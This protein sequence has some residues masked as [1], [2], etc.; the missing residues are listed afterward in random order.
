[1]DAGVGGFPRTCLHGILDL[2]DVAVASLRESSLDDFDEFPPHLAFLALQ[3]DA[4]VAWQILY[5]LMSAFSTTGVPISRYLRG[6]HDLIARHLTTGLVSA[7]LASPSA[8]AGNSAANAL[9]SI[10]LNQCSWLLKMA[11][12]EIQFSTSQRTYLARLLTNL[13]ATGDAAATAA[14]TDESGVGFSHGASVDRF[15]LLHPQPD[16][17][18]QGRIL[19]DLLSHMDPS[20]AMISPLWVF[21]HDCAESRLVEDI[22]VACEEPFPLIPNV[23]QAALRS[24]VINTLALARRLNVFLDGASGDVTDALVSDVAEWAQ[25]RNAHRLALVSGKQAY[26]EGWR[27]LA[28]ISMRMLHFLARVNPDVLS[29]TSTTSAATVSVNRYLFS[30]AMSLLGPMLR[31]VC[32][33]ETSPAVLKVLASGSCLSLAAFLQIFASPSSADGAIANPKCRGAQGVLSITQLLL[34]AVL[35]SSEFLLLLIPWSRLG[36]FSID[37]FVHVEDA[38]TSEPT[39]QRARANYYG[40]LCYVLDVCQQLDQQMAASSDSTVGPPMALRAINILSGSSDCD[41]GSGVRSSLLTILFNDLSR[42]HHPIIPISALGLLCMLMK[43]DRASGQI[44]ETVIRDG[45]LQS[46]VDSLEDDLAILQ[47]FLLTQSDSSSSTGMTNNGTGNAKGLIDATAV[48]YV[49]QSKMAFLTLAASTQ[50]GA[51]SLIQTHLLDSTLCRFEPLSGSCLA[52]AFNFSVAA[53]RGGG[54]GGDIANENQSDPLAWLDSHEFAQFLLAMVNKEEAGQFFGCASGLIEPLVTSQLLSVSGSSPTT[55]ADPGQCLTWIGILEPALAFAKALAFT[56][57]PSHVSAVQKVS[58]F[59]YTHSDA[60]LTVGASTSAARLAL[61]LTQECFQEDGGEATDARSSG[62]QEQLVLAILQWLHGE[63]SLAHLLSFILRA[64]IPSSL[65]EPDDLPRELLR[66]KTLRHV[67][68]ILHDL[69]Q[70]LQVKEQ[71]SLAATGSISAKQT[72]MRNLITTKQ[73][74]LLRVLVTT[75]V[76]AVSTEDEF[77][78]FESTFLKNL[79]FSSSLSPRVPRP[80]VKLFRLCLRSTRSIHYPLADSTGEVSVSDGPSGRPS[81]HL[82]L[83]LVSWSASRL[84]HLETAVT[85]TTRHLPPSLLVVNRNASTKGEE[86]DDSRR[87]HANPPVD[88]VLQCL[89]DLPVAISYPGEEISTDGLRQIATSIFSVWAPITA[90]LLQTNT[91]GIDAGQRN[92]YLRRFIAVGG[93]LLQTQLS[94]LIG[95]F[96][97]RPRPP[98]VLE[99]SLYLLWR[100][101]MCFVNVGGSRQEVLIEAEV[102]SNSSSTPRPPTRLPEVDHEHLL[103]QLPRR[104]SFDLL[105]S[106]TQVSKAPYLSSNDQLFLQVMVQRLDRLSQTRSRMAE[107]TN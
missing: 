28:E 8:P 35:S 64:R 33:P 76:A 55:S 96:S 77:G 19:A 63:E 71:R 32:A 23:D 6:N 20:E 92:A 98:H 5:H 12:I 26:L 94:C 70:A 2:V 75:C 17:A 83:Q 58:R 97:F 13:F 1:M 14:V 42:G 47:Q 100:H 105:D 29:L 31:Q 53:A 9:R 51:K 65:A 11:A 72:F 88:K 68:A 52:E 102:R 40:A 4:A 49:Y 61:A 62:R 66:S 87:V 34:E 39:Q 82:L 91:F 24:G 85:S 50:L 101:V 15:S 80:V 106:V 22:V 56:L 21:D 81:L 57:G 86:G 69:F 10:V 7:H 38:V 79:I 78:N 103:D 25:H 37:L 41:V 27:H 54:S 89:I 30:S 90:Q 95:W 60:L 44:L 16:S 73:L 67:F 107:R 104:L 18:L 48:F 74:T 45:C 59:V 84:H 99:Q 36:F 3:W 93:G 43:L 46:C